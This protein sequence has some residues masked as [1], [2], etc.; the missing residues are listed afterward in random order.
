MS[1]AT[2]KMAEKRLSEE[3]QLFKKK[4]LDF[5][6]VQSVSSEIQ[7]RIILDL[8]K[9]MDMPFYKDAEKEKIKAEVSIRLVP[10]CTDCAK[11]I[12]GYL[13]GYDDAFADELLS[14]LI[15]QQE[16]TFRKICPR[17][18]KTKL[19]K[20]C[21][22]EHPIP[23]SYSK[24]ILLSYIKS[25]D[26]DK[27]KKYIDYLAAIPQITLPKTEDAKLT[28]ALKYSMPQ[29]WNWEKDDKFARYADAGID[30]KYYGSI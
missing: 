25:K 29:G 30:P 13:I 18:K 24:D 28:G 27:A 7:Y 22:W 1:T 2:K 3:V 17:S 21:I 20:D 19:G 9:K 6:K 5:F 11:E 8:A 12:V 10:S 23:A 15:R 16:Q 26:L 14:N 4:V